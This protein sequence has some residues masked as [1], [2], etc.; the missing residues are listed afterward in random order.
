MVS[1]AALK[2]SEGREFDT[3]DLD[4]K[5]EV[6]KF[7]ELYLWNCLRYWAKNKPKGQTDV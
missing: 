3:P 6:K 5:T 1:R 4:Y 2:G 7:L